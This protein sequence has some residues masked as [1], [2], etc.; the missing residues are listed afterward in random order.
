M[1]PS[2]GIGYKL[3]A[4]PATTFNVDGGLGAKVEKNPGLDQRTDPSS[5]P[6]TSSSTSCRKTSTLTQSFGALWKAQ[7]F[8]DAL[9]TFAA[10]AAAA[11]TTAD[12]AEARAARHLRLA[13]AD[14]KRSRAT[15]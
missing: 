4:T 3:V 14:A 11:L 12:P 9:Y 10:G 2:G 13:P 6:R 8:G 5:P 1:A 15:T 7:D